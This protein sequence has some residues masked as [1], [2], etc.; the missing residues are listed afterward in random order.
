MCVQVNLSLSLSL[1]VCVCVCVFMSSC[2]LVCVSVPFIEQRIDP[3][4]QH[5]VVLVHLHQHT[6]T[7]V[8]FID[9][10]HNCGDEEKIQKALE[11]YYPDPDSRSSQ[12]KASVV[13]FKKLIPEL[14]KVVSDNLEAVLNDNYR[15]KKDHCLKGQ[16]V[17]VNTAIQVATPAQ[18]NQC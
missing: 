6:Q 13:Y 15:R 14:N 7:A 18:A 8:R 17:G 5:F 16:T 9:Y 3:H 2:V 10:C 11:D 4:N 12:N 1:C